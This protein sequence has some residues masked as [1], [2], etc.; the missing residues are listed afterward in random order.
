MLDF[1]DL[2]KN[3]I[4]EIIKDSNHGSSDS[5]KDFMDM[6]LLYV[7]EAGEKCDLYTGY[8]TVLTDNRKVVY[9]D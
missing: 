9:V 3:D 7:Y 1:K 4:D 2:T 5:I 6:G 8:S